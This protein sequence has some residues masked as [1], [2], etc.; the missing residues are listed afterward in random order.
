MKRQ[1]INISKLSP[2]QI[3]NQLGYETKKNPIEKEFPLNCI[4][5]C[6]EGNVPGG[7]ED[8]TGATVYPIKDA[9]KSIRNL[10]L[11]KFR[12]T[13]LDTYEFAYIPT[14]MTEGCFVRYGSGRE[15][16]L[17]TSHLLTA[18]ALAHKTGCPSHF[19]LYAENTEDVAINLA[20]AFP[21]AM[22]VICEDQPTDLKNLPNNVCQLTPPIKGFYAQVLTK[23][24]RVKQKIDE[25][26][27]IKKNE[28]ATKEV[29]KLIQ[30]M[31]GINGGTLVRSL[32]A[33]IQ[34]CSSMSEGSALLVA[35]YV[36]FTYLTGKVQYAPLLGLCSPA[37]RC[38][39]TVVLKLAALLVKSP[40]YIKDVTKSALELTTDASKTPLM[41]ELDQFIK[42]TDLVGLLNSGVEKGAV[43]AQTGKNGKV[44]HRHIYGAKLYAMIG[45]P[46]ETVF[47]RSI[48]VSM[49]RKGVT[50]IKEKVAAKEKISRY[51]SSEVSKWCEANSDAFDAMRVAPLDVSNDRARDNYE[52]LLRIAACISDTVEKEVRAAAVANALL[53]Q[54]T[55]DSGE[56]LICDIKRI[57]DD[58]GL[59][60]ISSADLV[61]KLRCSEGG[62]W[63]AS[64]GN[65]AIGPIRMAQMLEL[66]EVSPKRIWI[67]GKQVRGY[68]RES[69]EDAF[70]RYCG[71]DEGTM[72]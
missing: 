41:D 10:L 71:K 14:A 67:A 55:D 61:A 44:V 51:L 27:L 21:D 20:N 56:Q 17:V 39:K 31:T 62:V 3:W 58:T 30:K 50:E 52:P 22:V 60:A 11:V 34:S 7:D 72:D 63:S 35:L 13:A 2:E 5:G 18:V 57:F 48:I 40:S 49:K 15:I 54:A 42:N 36:F 25:C 23:P 59:K 33:L 66:F 37:R 64:N 45:R 43:N 4:T 12:T 29:T 53:Q 16:L 6:W 26:I 38:G 19:S 69:F 47:D 9:T 46:P 8:F 28:V 68:S 70:A 65:K 1:D 24:K 32:V